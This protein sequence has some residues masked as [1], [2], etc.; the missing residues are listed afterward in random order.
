[1]VKLVIEPGRKGPGDKV[2]RITAY[3]EIPTFEEVLTILDV[4][5]RSEDSLY[6]ISQ[7]LQGRAMLMKAILDVYSGI[8]IKRILEIY[9]LERKGK[10]PIV[11]EKLHEVL[12]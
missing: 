6:P 8:S 4:I 11:L 3:N 7:G 9:R 5:F 10:K 12:E 2:I 1:M